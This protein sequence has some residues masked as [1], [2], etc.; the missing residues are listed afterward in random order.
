MICFGETEP[1]IEELLRFYNEEIDAFR[2][3]IK[4][5]LSE[6]RKINRRLSEEAKNKFLSELPE[7][8]V[9][10][11]YKNIAFF[12]AELKKSKQLFPEAFSGLRSKKF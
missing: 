1:N 12:L 6:E 10:D 11:V 5:M 7:Y 8:K 9:L 4:R 2:D 3:K